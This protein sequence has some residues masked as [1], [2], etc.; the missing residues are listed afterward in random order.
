MDR[1]AGRD[2]KLQLCLNPPEN[3]LYIELVIPLCHCG[4]KLPAKGVARS[5]AISFPL[6]E[7]ASADFASLA[8][9]EKRGHSEPLPFLSLRAP[10]CRGVAISEDKILN[11]TQYQMTK[12]KCQIKLKTKRTKRSSFGI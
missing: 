10:T 5:V 12:L 6:P 11:T 8:T 7:I 9:T 4:P 3:W 1:G 2:T